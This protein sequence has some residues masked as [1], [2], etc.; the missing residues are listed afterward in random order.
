MQMAGLG[1]KL[2]TSKRRFH[3]QTLSGMS[4]LSTEYR[5]LSNVSTSSR[6]SF[7]ITWP[8]HTSYYGHGKLITRQ[9]SQF[10][11]ELR[12][13]FFRILSSPLPLM[14]LCQSPQTQIATRNASQ[15]NIHC[16]CP[17]ALWISSWSLLVWSSLFS[18]SSGSSSF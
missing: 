12:L 3:W 16:L 10:G 14:L 13:E 17:P 2:R 15:A 8:L 18:P 11:R 9:L 5:W 4:R 7:I 6:Y 1:S